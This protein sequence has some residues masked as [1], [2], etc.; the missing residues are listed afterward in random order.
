M[1]RFKEIISTLC[2]AA[3][4]FLP[5]S[6]SD[7]EEINS[8]STRLP[9]G[10]STPDKLLFNLIHSGNWTVYYYGF[11]QITSELMQY[12]IRTDVMSQVFNYVILSNNLTN[13]WSGLQK[14]TATAIHMY[15]MAVKNNDPNLQ[16]V[17]LTMKAYYLSNITDVFGD[18]PYSEAYQVKGT[19]DDITHPK[20]DDQKSIYQSILA[21]LE[22]ANSLYNVEKE[23]INPTRDILYQGDFK[24][25]QKF[26]NSLHLRLLLRVSK[27]AEM[28]AGEEMEKIVSDPVT[29][30]LFTDNT[31]AAILYYTGEN[32]NYNQTGASGSLGNNALA[33]NRKMAAELVD[34]MNGCM[35][36]R[37]P[38]YMTATADGRYTGIKSGY[39]YNY[40]AQMVT[41]GASTYADALSNDLWPTTFMDY[42]ELN[43]ILAEAALRGL[44]SGGETEAKTYHNK[45]V[46]ASVHQWCG[47][48]VSSNFLLT[49]TSAKFD[50]TVERIIGQKFVASFLNGFEAWNDYR[51]TRFPKLEIGPA[52]QNKDALG[53]SHLPTRLQYPSICQTANADQYYEQVRKMGADDMLVKVWWAEGTNY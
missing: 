14:Q 31:D 15:N 6:C 27:Q 53:I 7:F 29:Y 23:M 20:F 50:G 3:L 33:K 26:T 42:A 10:S 45:G 24:K 2:L 1:K 36:P 28:N 46:T 43:F 19:D 37:L 22:T 38:K 48:N 51:R 40:I 34:L 9:Y 12:S 41:A 18:V 30:P 39:D 32:P 8:D 35:D 49:D 17:A 16:A 5:A 44:I 11:H 4:L 13:I 21:D 25:W 47:P 52:A